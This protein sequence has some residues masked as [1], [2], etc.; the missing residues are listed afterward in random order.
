MLDLEN[1]NSLYIYRNKSELV[2]EQAETFFSEVENILVTEEW[3]A[4]Y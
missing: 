1:L 3:P 4:G 2:K